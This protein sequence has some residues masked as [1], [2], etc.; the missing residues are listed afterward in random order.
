M[1][2]FLIVYAHPVTRSFNR[3]ILDTLTTTLTADGHDVD[4]AD[5]YAEGFQPAMTVDDFNQFETDK[6]MPDDVLTEQARLDHA[7]HLIFIFP[8]W[9]WS[10]PA[11]LKGWFD[12]VMSYGYAYFDGNPLG[13]PAFGNKKVL[14]LATAANSQAGFAKRKYD[15]AAKTQLVTGVFD[16]CGFKDI[17]LKIFHDIDGESPQDGLDAILAN[18]K[19]L[20][21]AM[22]TAEVE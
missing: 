14:L 22:T 15:Q 9:W 1:A 21:Q 17:T 7:D 13:N 5:L 19:T 3:A 4:V 6:P 8:V 2:N 20:S 11:I 10:V 12:R 16:Y 18:A